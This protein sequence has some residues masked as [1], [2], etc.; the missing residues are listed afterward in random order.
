MCGWK[1]RSRGQLI[2]CLLGLVVCSKLCIHVLLL[3][4]HR[5]SADQLLGTGTEY[6]S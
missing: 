5:L 1:E 4:Q 6:Q 3:E 2:G